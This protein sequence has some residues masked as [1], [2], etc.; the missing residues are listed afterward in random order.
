MIPHAEVD[1]KQSDAKEA[2]FASPKVTII[3][4]TINVSRHRAN[5]SPPHP[6]QGISARTAGLHA[7]RVFVLVILAAGT[8]SWISHYVH[9]T[10]GDLQ[11]KIDLPAASSFK[12][13]ERK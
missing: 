11:K 8:F 10:N 4:K 7:K 6:K 1:I 13:Q 9:R 5:V 2:S 3:S 12:T